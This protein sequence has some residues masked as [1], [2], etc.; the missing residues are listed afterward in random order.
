MHN[1]YCLE[2]D[3]MDLDYESL[4]AICYDP[5]SKSRNLL[6]HQ[7]YVSDDKYMQRIRERY[8]FMGSLFNVY[9]LKSGLPIH[10]DAKRSCAV[11]IPVQN[12]ENSST[13][14]YSHPESP[15]TDYDPKLVVYR[16]SSK[17]NEEYRMTL[18]KPTLMNITIPHSVENRSP[19]PRVTISW[20]LSRDINYETACRLFEQS[21]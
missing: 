12:T 8:P 11:N 9:F 14:W 19:E 4:Y 10:I 2:L 3:C 7:R 18:R 13:I 21:K 16:I 15:S 1:H 5:S 17:V 6:P 20:G